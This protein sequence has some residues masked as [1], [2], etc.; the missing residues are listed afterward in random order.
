MK[1]F[2]ERYTAWVDGEL[3]GP[4]LTAFELE[5]SRRAA[6]GEARADKSDATRLHTLLTMHLQAPPLTNT[7]FFNHQLRE[8]IEADRTAADHRRVESRARNPLFAWSFARLAGLGGAFLF[9]AVALYYGLMPQNVGSPGGGMASAPAPAPANTQLADNS[10]APV[11]PAVVPAP[12]RRDPAQP[13]ELAQRPPIP[14]TIDLAPDDIQKVQV[15]DSSKTT[16]VTPLHYQKPD[17]NVI[18][19]NGLD[20]LPTV[21]GDTPAAASPAPAPA[22]TARP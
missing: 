15:P 12:A 6:A 20:Y 13:L 19:I 2:E 18:W 4:A 7:D 11:A 14:P 3:S 10:P 16:T 8:R 9:V 5:L 17:V 21:P 1:T 22:G